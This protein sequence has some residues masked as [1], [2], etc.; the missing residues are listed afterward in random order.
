MFALEA[1]QN[2]SIFWLSNNEYFPWSCQKQKN[3]LAKV[4]EEADIIAKTPLDLHPISKTTSYY[5]FLDMFI[6]I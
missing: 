2:E 6:F 3:D 4:S 5:Y 1:C